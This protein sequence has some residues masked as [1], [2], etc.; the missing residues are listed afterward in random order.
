MYT[1]IFLY[2]H[3]FLYVLV[4]LLEDSLIKNSLNNSQQKGKRNGRL[5]KQFHKA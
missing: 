3:M 2:T 5:P 1:Y 4:S